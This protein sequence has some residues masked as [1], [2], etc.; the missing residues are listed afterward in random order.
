MENNKQDIYIITEYYELGNLKNYFT[1]YQEPL[2][3]PVKL[4]LFRHIVSGMIIVH[5][6][7]IIHRDLSGKEKKN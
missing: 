2:E 7:D 4:S 5:R 3:I 6:N 1:M